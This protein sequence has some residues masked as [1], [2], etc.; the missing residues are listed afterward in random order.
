MVQ[1]W[2]ING[3]FVFSGSVLISTICP[4]LSLLLLP[5]AA[6][7][8]PRTHFNEFLC[9]FQALIVK[10][11]V[12]L[13]LRIL[14]CRHDLRR[15]AKKLCE[16]EDGHGVKRTPTS[17][18]WTSAVYHLRQHRCSTRLITIPGTAVAAPES[19]FVICQDGT[20][21]EAAHRA[22]MPRRGCGAAGLLQLWCTATANATIEG[23]ALTLQTHRKDPTCCH[24]FRFIAQYAANTR[25]IARHYSSED[26]TRT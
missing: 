11:L 18:K 10:A 21:E 14:I 1:K 26:S 8:L 13:L 7:S 9:S 17:F 23:P 5:K 16:S 2:C 20:C 15:S 24:H 3:A 6:S 22:Y 12:L 19:P 25:C 4:V